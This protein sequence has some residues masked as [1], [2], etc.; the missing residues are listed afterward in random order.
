MELLLRDELFSSGSAITEL[1]R[2]HDIWMVADYHIT[3]VPNE[4]YFTNHSIV[5]LPVT[6]MTATRYIKSFR[7]HRFAIGRSK[8]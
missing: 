5:P 3:P 4:V 8:K 1:D 7:G 2:V 6:P